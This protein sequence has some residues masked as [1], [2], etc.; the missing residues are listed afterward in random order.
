[1][2]VK[3]KQKKGTITSSKGNQWN[4]KD[5]KMHG[6]KHVYCFVWRYYGKN[7]PVGKL[8]GFKN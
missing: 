5:Y 4:A 3:I 7:K 1:M 2:A 6:I 8:A